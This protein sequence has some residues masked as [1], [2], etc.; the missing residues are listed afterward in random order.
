VIDAGSGDG[1]AFGPKAFDGLVECELLDA[2]RRGELRMT[3]PE[4]RNATSIAM[5]DAM[6]RALDEL[7]EAGAMEVLVV[8]G[9][10]RS[11]CAGLDLNEVQQGGETVHTLLRRLGEVMRRLRRLTMPVIAEVQGAA[12][13]GGFGFLCA[14]DFAVVESTAKIGYP[15]VSTGLSPALM[16]PWLF[17]KIGPS[18]ARAMMLGGGWMSGQAAHALGLA[19][20]VAEGGEERRRIVDELAG[21]VLGAPA[22]SM[23]AMKA[24]FND[25]DGSD[26][27]DDLLDRAATVSATI[28]ASEAVQ[29]RLR[30]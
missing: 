18:R 1:G 5:L 7:L 25:L 22:G 27:E 24:F 28:M 12:L 16:A 14:A 26:R 6:D 8:S 21:N 11:F 23:A 3:R 20:H 30:G 2:G 19:T 29:E 15:P 17:R 10:G 9:A 13:G 4:R